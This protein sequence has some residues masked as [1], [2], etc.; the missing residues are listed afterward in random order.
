MPEAA[1]YPLHIESCVQ[2]I[3]LKGYDAVEGNG[4]GGRA[5]G[6]LRIF[7]GESLYVSQRFPG[8]TINKYPYYVY[9]CS[10]HGQ[11]WVPAEAVEMGS[12]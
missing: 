8:L 3:A 12:N 10:R 9:A 11:G 4:R 2:T 6:Y 5:L 1:S 7:A